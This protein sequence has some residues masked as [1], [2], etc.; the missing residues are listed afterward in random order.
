[1][2]SDGCASILFDPE[3]TGITGCGEDVGGIEGRIGFDADGG[4]VDLRDETFCDAG[5]VSGFD[6]AHADGGRLWR[7]EEAKAELDVIRLDVWV[8]EG[9]CTVKSGVSF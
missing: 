8:E 6:D 5:G 2:E 7:D 1:M 3:G 9:G 4:A